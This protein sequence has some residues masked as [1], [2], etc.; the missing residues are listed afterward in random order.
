MSFI[1]VRNITKMYVNSGGTSVALDNVSLD[2]EKGSFVCII[3]GSGCG[4]T[5]LINL[6]AGFEHPDNGSIFIDG[7]QVEK[8]VFRHQTIFQNYGL[9]PWRTVEGN[10]SFALENVR[11]ISHH[12]KAKQVLEFIELV[13]LMSCREMYPHQLS[14]GMKQRVAIARALA[15]RPDV[16]FMD[17]PFGALDAINRMKLQDEMLNICAQ[18]RKTIV[19]ITHDIDEALY[20]GDRIVVMK[21]R[22][23][24]IAHEVIPA[25]RKPRERNGESFLHQRAEL[26]EL[27]DLAA[28]HKDVD[29]KI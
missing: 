18:Q 29:Y 2:I 21:P 19:L 4:K 10:V 12:Q 17:E 7:Q 3:G 15:A 22:P 23:G 1:E 16:I 28:R 6:L 8:P 13:G 14:G 26:L 27:L 5:T 20:L 9:L 25:T 24:R 11:D